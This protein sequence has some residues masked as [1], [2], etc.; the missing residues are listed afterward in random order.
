MLDCGRHFFDVPFVRKM[1]DLMALYKL[2]R[3][4]WHLTEDQVRFVAAKAGSTPEQAAQQLLRHKRCR[5]QPLVGPSCRSLSCFGPSCM[6]LRQGSCAAFN[7]A[8]F[9][10]LSC[11]LQGWRLEIKAFPRLTEKGA[12]RGRAG[13]KGYGGFYSQ[14]EV[15]LGLQSCHNG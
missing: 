7:Q 15:R 13:A 5:N 14:Q 1:L 4:H 11:A 12:W 9:R 6:P 2:N 8:R 10:F 3:F